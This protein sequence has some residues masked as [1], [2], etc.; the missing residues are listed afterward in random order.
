[1]Q[2]E[3][4]VSLFIVGAAKAGTTAIYSHLALH[5]EVCMCSLKEPNFF[6][7]GELVNDRL[8]YN[9]PVIQNEKEYHLLFKHI[10]RPVWG[11]A[12]VSY[13]YYKG[14]A[15]KIFS[16]N[17]QSRIIIFLRNPAERAFS[18]YLM[19]RKLGLVPYTFD[20]I[21]SG[22]GEADKQKFFRQY[23]SYGFYS[24][25]MDNYLKCFPRE[26]VKI[27]LYD[28]LQS[29]MQQVLNEVADFIPLKTPLQLLGEN[30]FNEAAM[31]RGKLV[32]A[33]YRHRDIRKMLKSAMPSKATR[34]L[35]QL[36]FESPAE[37][38][39]DSMRQQLNRYYKEDIQRLES[40]IHQNLRS[41][42]D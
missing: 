31:P 36:L 24:G 7:A 25:Q 34:K 11:E 37:K 38:L 2:N 35:K 18:H 4:K 16:Y 13:L 28:Q 20:E 8:Y 17:P 33:I 30:R 29:S 1:M 21:F 9:E 12:S 5:P 19:D 40:L 42:Y 22:I 10:T 39:S 6:S 14:T 27:I 32:S 15:K 41:W 26:Q 23:F 3:R